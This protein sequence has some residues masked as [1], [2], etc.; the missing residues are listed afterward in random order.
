M[1]P[2]INLKKEYSS[3]SEELN[4]KILN[5]LQSG[6]YI[7][8]DEVKKF[9]EDFSDMI[10]IKYAVSVNSGSDAL[11][12]AINSLGVGNDDEVITVSHTFISTAD[13]IVRT[14][15]K[16]IFVDINPETYCIDVSKIEDKIIDKTKAILVV[17]IYGHPIDMDPISKLA[18]KYNLFLIEDAFQA[19]GA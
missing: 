11:F 7:L 10:R 2:F 3:I 1:I 18:N 14:G 8:G 19:H 12:L 13:A 4:Q 6:Y 15:V 16:P 9:E 5:I 17:H